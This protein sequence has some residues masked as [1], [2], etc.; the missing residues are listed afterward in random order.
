MQSR[1][2]GKRNQSFRSP[3]YLT[4][5][6]ISRLLKIVALRQQIIIDESHG[7]A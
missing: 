4:P 5:L 3:L 7:F 6:S 2:P 1:R